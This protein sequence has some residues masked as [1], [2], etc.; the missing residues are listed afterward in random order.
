[1]ALP[2]LEAVPHNSTMKKNTDIQLIY[3]II[4]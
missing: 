4:S 3:H 2:P 1:L